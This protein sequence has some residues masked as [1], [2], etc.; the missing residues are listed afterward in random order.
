MSALLLLAIFQEKSRAA[1]LDLFAG[2]YQ[3]V[4][5]TD[6]DSEDISNLGA[7]LVSYQFPL[8]QQLELG[9]GYTLIMSDTIGGDLAFGFDLGLHYYPFTRV[10]DLEWSKDGDLMKIEEIWRPFATLSF[11]QRQFQSVS[12]S[13]A[14]FSLGGGVER[15]MESLPFNLKAAFRLLFLNGPGSSTGEENILVLGISY[16]L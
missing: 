13:Y 3:L 5:E 15:S 7:Y 6:T 9:L 4:A 8:Q 2:A 1:K 16:P 12:A 11:H 10:S 14:G